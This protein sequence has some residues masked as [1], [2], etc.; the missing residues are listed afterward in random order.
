MVLS[1]ILLAKERLP[2]AFSRSVC[3]G[4]TVQV[5]FQWRD[6]VMNFAPFLRTTISKSPCPNYG[7]S[8]TGSFSSLGG[9]LILTCV[10]ADASPAI[11][12]ERDVVSRPFAAVT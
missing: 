3:K 2:I 5:S 7:R 11:P 8:V 12:G 6:L 1:N 10:F 9:S 4:L